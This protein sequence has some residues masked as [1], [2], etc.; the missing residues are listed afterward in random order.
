MKR[1]NGNNLIEKK[2]TNAFK[3]AKAKVKNMQDDLVGVITLGK[4]EINENKTLMTN[5]IRVCSEEGRKQIR[6][7]LES[8]FK[9]K[10]NTNRNVKNM[11]TLTDLRDIG[12]MH[13]ENEHKYK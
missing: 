9:L 1:Q 5:Q 10:H 2:Y 3:S 4:H 6:Q 8:V 11:Q 13:S 12:I 7:S